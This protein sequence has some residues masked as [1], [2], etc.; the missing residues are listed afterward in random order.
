MFLTSLF[1]TSSEKHA[2]PDIF[3]IISSSLIFEVLLDFIESIL[4]SSL[5]SLNSASGLFSSISK[6]LFKDVY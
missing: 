5:T 2:E 6:L 4:L 1:Q 3:K